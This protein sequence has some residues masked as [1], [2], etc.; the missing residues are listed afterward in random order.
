MQESLVKIIHNHNLLIENWFSEKWKINKAP[1]YSSVDI[2]NNGT[3][4]A[5]IDMNLFPAGFNNLTSESLDEAQNQLK[6]LFK[7][8]YPNVQKVLLIPENHTRNIAYLNNLYSLKTLL[9]NSGLKVVIGSLS[10]EIDQPTEVK[11]EPDGNKNLL[12][13]PILR[14]QDL[15]HIQTGFTPDLIILNNDLS[16]GCPEILTNVKQQLIPPLTAGWYLR[17]KSNHFKFY[18][19]VC[20]EFASI[21]EIN[22]DSWLL[23]PYFDSCENLDFKNLI[24][25]EELAHKVDLLLNKI[26]LKYKE[27][28]IQEKPYVVIKA[29]SGTYGMGIM[30]VDD[31]AQ[32]LNPNRRTR[33]KMSVIKEGQELSEVIIQEGIHTIDH[34]NNDTSEPVLYMINSTVIGSF[35]RAHPSRAISDNLNTVGAYFTSLPQTFLSHANPQGYAYSVVSRLALLAGSYELN[36]LPKI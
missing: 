9:E 1:F 30:I 11:L 34:Y 35:Y 7:T 18:S 4:I 31:A 14:T 33:N 26:S 13:Y 23:D 16:S 10:K 24:G 2:R 29:D 5:S 3:K 28:N 19:Q 32:I 21:P 25:L 12:Y 6:I 17:R 22:I 15:I 36:S 20:K 27:Y 8:N